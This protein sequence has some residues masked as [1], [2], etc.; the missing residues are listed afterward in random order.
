MVANDPP[1]LED[2]RT[3]QELGRVPEGCDPFEAVG[4][5]VI[6]D[7][8]DASRLRKRYPRMAQTLLKYAASGVLEPRHGKIKPTPRQKNESHH[9]WWKYDKV[10]PSPD[11]TILKGV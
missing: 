7:Q 6:T 11:F 2:F 10:D 8:E 5:S 3:H 1:L 4:L 9:T